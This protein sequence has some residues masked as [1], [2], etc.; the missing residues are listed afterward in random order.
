MNRENFTSKKRIAEGSVDLCATVENTDSHYIVNH[1]SSCTGHFVLVCDLH[2][3][4]AATHVLMC[5]WCSCSCDLLLQV[6]PFTGKGCGNY[7]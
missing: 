2:Y 7:Q 6:S 5:L 1:D 3:A 4:F